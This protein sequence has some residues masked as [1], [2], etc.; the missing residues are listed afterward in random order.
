[1]EWKEKHRDE[2][3]NAYA[4]PSVGRLQQ[5]SFARHEHLIAL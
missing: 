5:K 1:M 3:N 2:Q 4:A